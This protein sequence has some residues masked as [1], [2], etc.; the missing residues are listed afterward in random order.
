MRIPHE[1]REDLGAV[2]KLLRF[3]TG[4]SQRE[5]ARAAGVS[6]GQ[7]SRYE[8][9]S[10]DPTPETL[11]RL[12]LAAGV[13]MIHIEQ[14]MPILKLYFRT[15][16]PVRFPMSPHASKAA[17]NLA[18]GFAQDIAGVCELLLTRG[19]LELGLADVAGVEAS[20]WPE[21]FDPLDEP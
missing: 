8:G 14:M 4:W 3:L 10:Q 16:P 2:V 11:E 19:I 20:P 18:Q 13:T 7:I 15:G 5:L 9:G 17:R 12:I 6:A 1:W 21:G